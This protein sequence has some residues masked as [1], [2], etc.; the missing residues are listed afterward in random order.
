MKISYNTLKRFKKDIKSPEEIA[1]DLIMHTAEV[2]EVIYEGKNFENMVLGEVKE[3]NSHP[4]ADKL[5]V[6]MVDI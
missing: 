5:K 6:C 3:I 4:D 2:E 1:Q